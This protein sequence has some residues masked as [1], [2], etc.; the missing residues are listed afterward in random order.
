MSEDKDVIKAPDQMV[1]VLVGH[2]DTGISAYG[3]FDDPELAED[4]MDTRVSPALPAQWMWITDPA[5][6]DD[7]PA[8]CSSCGNSDECDCDPPDETAT[9][10]KLRVVK[11]PVKKELAPAS[12][13]EQLALA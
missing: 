13:N 4:F 1:M 3:P 11:K 7:G 10:V 8:I 12:V 6:V 5:T 9:S 2:L